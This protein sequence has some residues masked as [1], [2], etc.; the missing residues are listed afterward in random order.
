MRK[1]PIIELRKLHNISRTAIHKETGI[2]YVTLYEL[3]RGKRRSPQRHVFIALAKFFGV[4][5]KKLM[6]EYT[7]WFH[8][9]KLRQELFTPLMEEKTSMPYNNVTPDRTKNNE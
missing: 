1:N 6:L 3:E 7:I 8:T 2:S 9:K 4:D 5:A